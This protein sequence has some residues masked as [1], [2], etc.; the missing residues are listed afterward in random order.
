KSH[1]V[2]EN[3][4]SVIDDVAQILVDLSIKHDI[5][6]DAPHHTSKGIAQPGNADR[7]RGASSLKDAGRLVYTITPMSVEEA[8]TYGVNEE[9]R[10]VLVRMDSG[11]VNIMPPLHLA[12]WYKLVGVM[13]GNV[14]EL[15]PNGDNV[16]AIVEWNPPE[17]WQGLSESLIDRILADI[18]KG[19]PD[20]NR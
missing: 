14:T 17:I 7:G 5:A 13:L 12:R 18:D 20:G 4:N 10:R 2:D 6:V 15:Y 3:N 16:Q 11:K 8:K 1:S 19:L 9:L